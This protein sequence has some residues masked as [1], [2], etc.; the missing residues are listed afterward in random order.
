MNNKICLVVSNCKSCWDTSSKLA[1]ISRS[2][3]DYLDADEIKATNHII[4][5]GPW[6]SKEY[7]RKSQQFV[8]ERVAR[9][10]RELAAVLNP[11]LGIDY[12]E[13]AWGIL[14]DSWLLHFTSVVHDR[15][16][17]LKNAQE[18]LGDIFLKCLKEDPQPIY[19]TVNFV[20]DTFKDLENQQL[21][22]IMFR[23]VICTHILRIFLP[24]PKLFI[25][26]QLTEN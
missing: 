11:A 16:N 26:N 2:T 12:S 13:K 25:T 14:L 23:L 17:K 4:L 10:R 21:L 24:S 19:V 20:R 9:Y 3:P 7:H 5:D 1:F 8:I 22:Q 6:N 15:V 18:K